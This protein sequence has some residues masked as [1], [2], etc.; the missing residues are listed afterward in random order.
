[1]KKLF[2]MMAALCC[3]LFSVMGAGSFSD[4][5]YARISYVDMTESGK[6]TTYTLHDYNEELRANFLRNI[7]STGAWYYNSPSAF[8]STEDFGETSSPVNNDFVVNSP[9]QAMTYYDGNLYYAAEHSTGISRVYSE[10]FDKLGVSASVVINETPGYGPFYTICYSYADS[11]FY[12]VAYDDASG[13]VK[14]IRIASDGSWY[15]SVGEISNESSTIHTIA[16][17]VSIDGKLYIL[18]ASGG[19]EPAMLYELNPSTLAETLI[20]STGVLANPNDYSTHTMVFDYATDELLWLTPNG[21]LYLVDTKTGLADLAK[22]TNITDC[23]AFFRQVAKHSVSLN[24]K[25]GQEELGNVELPNNSQFGW[26]PET[27]KVTLTAIPS[28]GCKFVKWSDNN[29]ENPRII[30][31]GN[32]NIE[33]T[34]EFAWAD[35][36]TAYPIWIGNKQIHS[37]RLV[38]NN[39]TNPYISMGSITYNPQTRTLLL[40]NLNVESSVGSTLVIGDKD[41]QESAIKVVL[42]GTNIITAYADGAILTQN[43]DVSF[44]GYGSIQTS[45][46]YSSYGMLISAGKVT[47]NGVEAT[48]NGNSYGIKG[49]KGTEALT[50]RGSTLKV[51]GNNSG[52]IVN[53]GSLTMKYC[54]ITSPSGAAFNAT[55]KQVEESNALTNVQVVFSPQPTLR[56]EA[57][58]EGTGTFTMKLKDGSG[59]MFTNVGWFAK[60]DEVTMTAKPASGF[61]F[62]RWMDDMNWGDEAK[63]DDWI[64]ATREITKSAG[65][66]TKAALFYKQSASNVVWYGISQDKFVQFKSREYGANVIESTTDA[67]GITAGDFNGSYYFIAE[68]GE[69]KR[70]SFSSVTKDKDQANYDKATKVA[71]YTGIIYDMAWNFKDSKLYAVMGDTKLYRLNTN[72]QVLDEM[73]EFITGELKTPITA[74]ALAI[75]ASGKKY[76][77]SST[78]KLYVV[79]KEDTK[80]KEFTL[81]PVGENGGDLDAIVFDQ[82]QSLAYDHVNGELYWGADD[83][84]RII[85]SKTAKS[86]IAGDLRLQKGYQGTI[87]ALH[88]RDR[89]VTVTVEVAEACKDMG[90]AIIGTEGE[91]AEQSMIQGT[92]VTISAIPA[93]GYQFAYWLQK[94]DQ[95]AEAPEQIKE[96]PYSFSASSITYVAYF[97][98]TQGIEDVQPD[99]VQCTKMLID[100]HLYIIRDNRMYN[101]QGVR[102]K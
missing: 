46:Y 30:T 102:V 8:Y 18:R 16:S 58:T 13:K 88:R 52:S 31:I 72:D 53:I 65:N 84:I 3:T 91:M 27:A 81:K 35:G 92:S 50:V 95:D 89:K 26:F 39:A 85:D 5:T 66:E 17:A 54:E 45:S 21:D 49:D 48:I 83:F 19:V 7:Q 25:E 82:P 40:D 37:Q 67:S 71:D 34:A 74:R 51:R 101:V 77:L 42:K 1:M 79:T 90:T 57:L 59:E 64:P 69:I 14:L 61:A 47:F 87:K 41:K 100:G 32:Q 4:G 2:T 62:G 76:I 20:G 15:S 70:F 97:E 55:T 23:N 29:T 11:Y 9:V 63:K 38:M 75:D 78:S 68:S 80:N 86:Y 36:V 96:K 24:V 60:D 12:T 43:V 10:A 22:K 73:G 33:L 6:E 98:A 94:V 56:G 44:E 28:E 93:E 99:N